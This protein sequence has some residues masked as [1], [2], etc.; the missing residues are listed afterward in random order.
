IQNDEPALREGLPQRRSD[1]D[2]YLQWGVEAIRINAAVAK[3]ATQ[4]HTHL[5]NCEFNDIMDTIAALDEDV[6]TI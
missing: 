2:A 6:I 4:I 3:D 5:S 1:W